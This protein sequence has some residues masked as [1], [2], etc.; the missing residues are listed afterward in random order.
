ML[1]ADIKHCSTFL[2]DKALSLKVF[3]LKK[4]L[5]ENILDSNY[6]LN[7]YLI[8]DK[9][10]PTQYRGIPTSQGVFNAIFK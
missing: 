2:T 10:S 8:Y 7:I 6:F 5:F 1:S 4:K 9:L 3:T